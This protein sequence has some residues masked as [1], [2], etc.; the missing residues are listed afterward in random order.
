[1]KLNPIC[2]KEEDLII[3]S[4]EMPGLYYSTK[5][6]HPIVM[7]KNSWCVLELEGNEYRE[8]MMLVMVDKINLEQAIE[9]VG[10]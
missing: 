2:I 3:E 4:R 10:V 6:I 1:M 8:L 9:L 5:V 7:Y